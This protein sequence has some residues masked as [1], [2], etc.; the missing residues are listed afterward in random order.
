[1]VLCALATQPALQGRGLG[2]RMVRELHHLHERTG[3]I[4]EFVACPALAAIPR[5]ERLGYDLV[6]DRQLAA[7]AC[8]RDGAAARAEQ[9]V[10]RQSVLR[11]PAATSA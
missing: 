4:R 9:G 10:A 5:F 2:S 3:V 6:M 8:K 11:R 7:A 1:V